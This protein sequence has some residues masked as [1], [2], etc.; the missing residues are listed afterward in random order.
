MDRWRTNSF[1]YK[2]VIMLVL[3]RRIGEV[4]HIGEG[5]SRI[6]LV[7]VDITKK[8]V[9]LGFV[10]DQRIPI[11]RSETTWQAQQPTKRR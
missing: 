4:I 9:R 6:E 11:M 10:C 7:I 1:F 5:E 3:S 8:K 2:E